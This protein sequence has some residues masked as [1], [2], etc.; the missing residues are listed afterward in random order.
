MARTKNRTV[1]VVLDAT[2]TNTAYTVWVLAFGFT[3]HQ[4]ERDRLLPQKQILRT[5]SG[6]WLLGLQLTK[7]NETRCYS[8]KYRA[9]GTKAP[10]NGKSKDTTVELHPFRVQ[11]YRPRRKGLIW[12]FFAFYFME[13]FLVWLS[14]GQ[15]LQKFLL[16]CRKISELYYFKLKLLK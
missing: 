14:R 9:R 11:R 8:L 4:K 16:S 2:K 12:S 10:V 15:R 6:C 1:K 13:T 7:K 5:L 3:A